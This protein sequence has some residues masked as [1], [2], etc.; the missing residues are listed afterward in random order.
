MHQVAVN[1]QQGWSSWFLI[2]DVIVPD[3]FE[4]CCGHALFPIVISFGSERLWTWA[5]DPFR[6]RSD[7]RC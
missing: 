3:L 5:L 6:F 2:D 4:K 7:I 1:V